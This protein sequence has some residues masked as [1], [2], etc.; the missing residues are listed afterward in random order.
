MAAKIERAVRDLL[1]VVRR[2]NQAYPHKAFT[3]DG[4]LV[5]DIGEV[6]VA[7]AYGI[8]LFDRLQH[9]H[10]GKVGR[11]LVQIKATMKDSLTFPADHVPDYY[12]GIKIRPDGTFRTVFNGPGQIIAARLARRKRPKNNLHSVSILILEGLDR[13]VPAT[14]RIPLRRGRRVRRRES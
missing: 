1:A 4:R 12:I 6:L 9:H 8:A 13:T 14:R 5:G 11:R 10:D 2:L 7:Q 3:L